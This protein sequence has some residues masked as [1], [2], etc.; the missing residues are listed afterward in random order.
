MSSAQESLH[1]ILSVRVLLY[2][3]RQKVYVDFTSIH[4]NEKKA[5]KSTPRLTANGAGN[6]RPNGVC[7]CPEDP[8]G[9]WS[10]DEGTSSC[11]WGSR[12]EGT[13]GNVQDSHPD[14]RHLPRQNGVRR[15]G[16]L[17]SL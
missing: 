10:P 1:K 13:D 11:S 2:G 17:K 4:R 6:P 15:R 3:Q 5:G 8:G 16:A 12:E 7:T 14:P 9:P